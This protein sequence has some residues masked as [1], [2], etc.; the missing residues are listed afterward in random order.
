RFLKGTDG[1]GRSESERL[2]IAIQAADLVANP[3]P[4]LPKLEIPSAL[5]RL[6]GSTLEVTVPKAEVALAS[7]RKIELSA[8]RFTAVD[9]LSDYPIAQIAF[10]GESSAPAITELIEHEAFG[11]GRLAEVDRE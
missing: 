7:G 2:S 3:G 4:G 9:I 8:G 11:I 6:E 10:R 5:I 1:A